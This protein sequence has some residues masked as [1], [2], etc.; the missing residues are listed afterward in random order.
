MRATD[1]VPLAA[2]ANWVPGQ[3]MIVALAL[4]DEQARERFGE[5]DIKLPYLRF[6]KVK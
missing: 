6:G 2:P 4:T 3:D 1:G 5:L